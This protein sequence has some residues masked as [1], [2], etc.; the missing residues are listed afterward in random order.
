LTFTEISGG[1][2]Y[3]AVS[4]ACTLKVDVRLTPVFDA[5]AA[6]ALLRSGE[7]N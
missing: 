5:T 7:R 6:K 1:T 2:G 4:H 3:S